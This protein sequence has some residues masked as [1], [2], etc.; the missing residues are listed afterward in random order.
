MTTAIRDKVK[1]EVI[2][3]IGYGVDPTEPDGPRE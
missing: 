2:E 1:E 3:F